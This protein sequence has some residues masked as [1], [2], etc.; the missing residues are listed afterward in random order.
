MSLIRALRIFDMF[1]NT[2]LVVTN[3]WLIN[4]VYTS[5]KYYSMCIV[6]TNNDRLLTVK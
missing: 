2:F 3:A 6:L 1:A 4:D 5:D